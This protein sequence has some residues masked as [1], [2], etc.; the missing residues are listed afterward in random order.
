MEPARSAGEFPRLYDEN[1]LERLLF[2]HRCRS[3]DMTLDEIRNLLTFR[4]RPE[5][6]CEVNELVD[7]HIVQK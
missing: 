7:A 1:H 6:D 5:L 2:I 4:D 3:R